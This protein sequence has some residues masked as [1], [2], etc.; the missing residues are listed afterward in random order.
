MKTMRYISIVVALVVVLSLPACS[1]FKV[2]FGPLGAGAAVTELG[3]GV[4]AALSDQDGNVLAGVWGSV[5]VPGIA[6]TLWRWLRGLLPAG[7]I[8]VLG[9]ADT[10]TGPPGSS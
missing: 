4:E 6:G 3:P 7:G 9:T 10:P 2:R 8:S 5:D 1:A